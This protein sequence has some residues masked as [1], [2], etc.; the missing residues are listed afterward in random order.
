[1]ILSPPKIINL[2]LNFYQRVEMRFEDFIYA[3]EVEGM[4]TRVIEK[5]V[6]ILHPTIQKRLS[7]QA[8]MKI[9]C[10]PSQKYH[11]QIIP[12]LTKNVNQQAP[13]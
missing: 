8:N 12:N 4:G 7:Y 10:K 1:M 13:K 2:A 5:M 3:W 6:S 11:N 9:V